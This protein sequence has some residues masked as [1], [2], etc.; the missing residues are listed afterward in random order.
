M[1]SPKSLSKT[2]KLHRSDKMINAVSSN[3]NIKLYQKVWHR[4]T[5]EQAKW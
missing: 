2:N 1:L 3:I 4:E 5:I